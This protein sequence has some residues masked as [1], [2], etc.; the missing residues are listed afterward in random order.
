LIGG[1]T[2]DFI[3]KDGIIRHTAVIPLE[4][5]I[6]DD[7]KEGCSIIEKQAESEIGLRWPG[8]NRDNEIV[9]IP[10]LRGRRKNS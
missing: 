2:T 6:S 1:G 4:E 10:G 5:M 8:E 3:F 9:S 7:I